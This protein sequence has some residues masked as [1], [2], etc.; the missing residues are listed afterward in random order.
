LTEEIHNEEKIPVVIGVMKGAV[1]FLGDL[2][3]YIDVPIFIDYIQISSYFGTSRTGEIHLVKDLTYDI[4][5]RTVI[6]VED[7]VDTGLSMEFL[8]KH[9]KTKYKPKRIII[10]A[11][12]DKPKARKTQIVCDY[13]GYTLNENKFLVGY[14]LD[15]KE[16]FRNVPYVFIPD[17]EDI[18]NW[19]ERINKSEGN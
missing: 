6:I 7:V 19:D 8:V 4:T 12:F 10:T 5:D 13:P 11:L 15:Y 17:E 14:G 18:K 16:L 2:V 3:K 1:H 9:L